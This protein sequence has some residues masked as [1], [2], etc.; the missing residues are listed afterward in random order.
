[1]KHQ[2]VTLIAILIG[3]YIV[4][5]QLLS[6][7][8]RAEF[9]R[10]SVAICMIVAA[11]MYLF[12]TVSFRWA[13]K[14][15]LNYAFAAKHVLWSAFIILFSLPNALGVIVHHA[16]YQLNTPHNPYSLYAV[17]AGI[18]TLLWIGIAL[19]SVSVIREF[20]EANWDGPIW[21]P[22]PR[23]K[24]QTTTEGTTT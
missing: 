14:T 3:I 24:A 23:W 2:A 15:P 18:R 19:T 16:P 8:G 22:V 9:E 4:I 7:L 17:P 11:V 21:R 10:Y 20:Y 1:M 6:P 13:R 12:I 5:W